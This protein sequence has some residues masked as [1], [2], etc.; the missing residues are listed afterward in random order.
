M[1]GDGDLAI[2][3]LDSLDRSDKPVNIRIQVAVERSERRQV[4][5]G[6]KDQPARRQ[7]KAAMA[8]GMPG[9]MENMHRLPARVK[10]M[11]VLE[12]KIH[13][14]I[15]QPEQVLQKAVRRLLQLRPGRPKQLHQ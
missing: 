15:T 3:L 5:I 11:P 8:R 13:A 1:R 9:S 4:D 2:E 7:V 14:G 6:Q 10:H 12:L